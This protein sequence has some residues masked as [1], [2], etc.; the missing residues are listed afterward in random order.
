[1]KI[2]VIG[3]IILD[4]YSYAITER[5]CQEAD[6]PVFDL[7]NTEY[8]LGGASN[9]A[10]NLVNLFDK[11]AKIYLSGIVGH[12]IVYRKLKNVGINSDLCFLG[13]TL[14]KNRIVVNE[15]IK[16]RIDNLKKIDGDCV[17]FF[18]SFIKSFLKKN[19]FDAVIISDY[20]KGTITKEIVD[21]L[22]KCTNLLIVDSKRFDLSL[23][24]NC[25]ILKINQYEKEIQDTNKN[26]IVESFFKY[27][28]I[29]KGPNG[30]EL[31]MYEQIKDFKYKINSID[32][33]VKSV[34]MKDVTGCGDTHTAALLYS[35]LG[36]KSDIFSAINFANE[37]AST[38]VQKF[39]TSIV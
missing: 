8:R 13:N 12:P 27:C 22:K 6:V 10:N 34:D 28:V 18:S 37:C 36:K 25:D 20:D 26:Y 14:V 33:P 11:Q 16:Y 9:V 5:Q 4:K 39:G 1:M 17:Q 21:F 24:K 38:V 19:A 3:D 31:R 2:L 35:I 7:L 29:T 32:F 23:Y 15:K 30:T